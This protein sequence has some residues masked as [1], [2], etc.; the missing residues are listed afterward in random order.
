M[1]NTFGSITRHFDIISS[2]YDPVTYVDRPWLTQLVYQFCEDKDKR[3]L[4]IVGEPGSGK[5]TFL[6]HLA[7]DW[8]CPRHF[9]RAGSISGVTGIDPRSF[10]ISLGIQLKQKYGGDIFERDDTGTTQVKARL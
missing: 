8:N 6:A 5:T 4:I 9:I 1:D 2:H 10:L 7:L 3:H